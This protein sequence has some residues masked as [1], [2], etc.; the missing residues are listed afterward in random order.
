MWGELAPPTAP[1]RACAMLA[2][3]DGG[4]AYSYLSAATGCILAALRAG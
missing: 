3:G 2:V 4:T 1:K